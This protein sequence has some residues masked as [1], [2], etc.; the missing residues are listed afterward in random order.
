MNGSAAF[1]S[2]SLANV[3][4]PAPPD[5]ALDPAAYLRSINA[6]RERSKLIH[7]KAQ[8]NQLAHFDVDLSKFGE[9]AAYVVSIIKVG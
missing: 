7:Q 6:V 2:P 4:L 3:S 1:T 9:T 8:K 5:P